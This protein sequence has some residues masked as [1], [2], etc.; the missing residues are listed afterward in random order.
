M[1]KEKYLVMSFKNEEGGTSRL[2]LKNVKEE[3]SEEEVEA[4]MD[5]IISANVFEFKGGN[6]VSKVKGEVIEKNIESFDMV[7]E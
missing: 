2:T 5:S 4:L 6:L 7:S 3:V 1:E